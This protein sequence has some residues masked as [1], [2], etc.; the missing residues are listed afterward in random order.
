M[1]EEKKEA[2]AVDFLS[3][4]LCIGKF[5]RQVLFTEYPLILIRVA[6]VAVGLS[7]LVLLS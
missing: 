4:I 7:P 1:N 6:L 3:F 2:E 5:W